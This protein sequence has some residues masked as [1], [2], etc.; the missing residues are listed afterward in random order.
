MLRVTLGALLFTSLFASMVAGCAAEPAAPSEGETESTEEALRAKSDEHWIYSGPMA[1]LQDAT[2]TASLAGSTAHV[3]G[4]L[5]NGTSTGEMQQLPNVKIKQVDGRT[6][7]DIVYPIATARPGKYNSPPGRYSFHGAKPYRPDGNAW[8][9]AEGEHWVTWGGFPFLAY[10]GGIAFHGPI[11]AQD[12]VG[13]PNMDVW[14]LRRGD[15]SGG[16]N[17]MMGEHVVELAHVL[18][19]SM[20]KVYGANTMYS[21][22]TAAKTVVI[23]DYDTFDGKYIDVD[24]A[25]DVGVTRPG[26]IHGN[27]RVA[28]FGSWVAS[29]LPDGR[30]LPQSMRWEGGVSG[31]AYVFKEH[32]RTDMVCSFAKQDLPGL[33]LVQRAT[34][35]ELP[36]SICAKKQCVVD[37]IRANAADS[38]AARCGL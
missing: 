22:P 31:K 33:K 38:A 23:A 29:E 20:R 19:I 12:N 1:A 36:R 11:T 30:D 14:Y 25:T 7:V 13:T 5:P 26:K 24:Y 15:V 9:A 37:A 6:R 3:V 21:N 10:N 34:G 4:Y 2:V 32:A 28:M 17:R 8:T 27:D 18:G 35:G 16:C